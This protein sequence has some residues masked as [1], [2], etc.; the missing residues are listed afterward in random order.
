MCGALAHVRFTPE[1]DIKRDIW[2]RP[3]WAK[4]GHQ[5]CQ[6]TAI[7]RISGGHGSSG[8]TDSDFGELAGLRIDLD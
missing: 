8:Q 4:S 5:A 2:E 7:G 6:V 1:S 3:L